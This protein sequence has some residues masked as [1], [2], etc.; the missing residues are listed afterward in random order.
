[1]L[2]LDEPTTEERSSQEFAQAVHDPTDKHA[3]IEKEYANDARTRQR[4]L[5]KETYY[6]PIIQ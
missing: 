2:Q 1:M 6:W 5:W 3:Q 4:S